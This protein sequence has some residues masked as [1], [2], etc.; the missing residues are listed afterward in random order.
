VACYST[1]LLPKMWRRSKDPKFPA[2]AARIILRSSA[3]ST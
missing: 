3:I 1:P 2:G